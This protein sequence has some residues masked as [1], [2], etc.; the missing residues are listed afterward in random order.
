MV[1]VI[2]GK[3]QIE[4]VVEFLAGFDL[5]FESDVDDLLGV[6]GD[7]GQLVATAARRH[8]LLKM[9]AVASEQQSGDVFSELISELIR[10]GYE[11]GVETFFVFTK[12]QNYLSFSAV[13]FRLLCVTEQVALL[14][15]GPGLEAYFKRHQGL[16]HQG[17]NGAVVVNCNPFTLG[18]RYLIETAAQQVDWLYVFVV[19]EDRSSFPFDVRFGLVRQ[20]VADLSNVIVLPSGPYAVSQITFPGYFL[21]SSEQVEHQQHRVD[22]ELF[23][24]HLAPYFHIQHRFVGSEPYCQTTQ[25]YNASLQRLLPV[26]GVDVH[27]LS[28]AAVANGAISAS[29]VRR[30]L[31]EHAYNALSQLVPE[32]TL[33]YL[34]SPACEQTVRWG[35]SHG[36]H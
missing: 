7:D 8:G 34:V 36:R 33:A 25:R 31:R 17:N 35:H 20:G 27:E 5:T 12:P 10:R 15:Y 19:E 3:K 16:R 23:T 24:R 18:H 11:A 22:A 29:Q 1:R 28:R 6:W 32:T 14:E 21:K 9:I 4:Q 30:L 13:N 2:Q 26:Q